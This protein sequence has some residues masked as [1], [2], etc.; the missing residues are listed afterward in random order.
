MSESFCLSPRMIQGNDH[1]LSTVAPEYSK[2][3]QPRYTIHINSISE[4]LYMN[5]E[6][7]PIVHEHQ[8]FICSILFII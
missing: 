5:N 4:K 7:R 1:G 3:A 2:V 6:N 8:L